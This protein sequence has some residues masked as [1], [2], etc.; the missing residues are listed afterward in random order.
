[1]PNSRTERP[2]KTKIGAGVVHVTGDSDITFKGQKAKGQGH[3]V[4]LLTAAL[5]HQAAAAV[6]VRTYWVWETT[7]TL[8]CALRRKA[9]TEGGEGRGISWRPPAYSLLKLGSAGI[10][11]LQ[12][13]GVADSDFKQTSPSH[14]RVTS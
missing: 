9:P 6:S 1:M 5:T 4:A 10:T 3:Q 14:I 13:D 8:R 12:M 11:P 7:A 2:R